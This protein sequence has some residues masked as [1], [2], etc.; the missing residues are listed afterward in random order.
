MFVISGFSF[1]V[2]LIVLPIEGLTSK[3]LAISSRL[4]I[5]VS[6]LLSAV[7]SSW[8]LDNSSRLAVSIA[9]RISNL[10]ASISLIRF[11]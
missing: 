8:N 4:R 1:S 6:S 2:K 11:I 3:D 10:R 7:N 5:S 9:L